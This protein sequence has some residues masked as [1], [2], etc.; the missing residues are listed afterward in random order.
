MHSSVLALVCACKYKYLINIHAHPIPLHYHSA[1]QNPNPNPNLIVDLDLNPLGSVLN[2]RM[3]T[4]LA[5]KKKRRQRK[6]RTILALKM[7]WTYNSLM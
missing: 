2:L 4:S 3:F 7:K 1:P 5:P 6:H